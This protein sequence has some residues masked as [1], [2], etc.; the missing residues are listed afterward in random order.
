M[1][2]HPADDQDRYVNIWA[3]ELARW[4]HPPGLKS[5]DRVALMGRE[6]VLFFVEGTNGNI[7]H[8][9]GRAPLPAGW[10]ESWE[11][12]V[13]TRR[14]GAARLGAKLAM[15]VVPDKLAVH[16]ER[17]PKPLAPA[18]P[19]PVQRLLALATDITYP[20]HELRAERDAVYLRTDR[21]LTLRGNAIL[22]DATLRD[23]ELQAPDPLDGTEAREQL[24]SGDLGRRMEPEVVEVV[25]V[26]P[27]EPAPVVEDSR[28][29]IAAVGG[30][31]G[32]RRVW[33]RPDAPR[34][35]TVVVFGDSYGFG[36]PSHQGLAW[37][38][39]RTFAEVHF[40]WVPFG[41]DEAYARQAGADV[42]VC[43]TAERFV[44]RV[45][46]PAVDVRELEALALGRG[47]DPDVVF[48]DSEA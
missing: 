33:R 14:E 7:E 16:A 13:R 40:A 21:H 44:V 30:H 43:E 5:A 48:S 3:R 19:R 22:H 36:D 29:R 24:D 20:L 17:F 27:Q 32:S 26:V 38:L 23:L 41:W 18:G 4:T 28:E 6:G 1:D 47:L 10:A 15:V 2:P 46:R 11:E 45:P 39:A 31:V 8:F 42:V 25:T 37:M 9:L 35:E 12:A 34:P